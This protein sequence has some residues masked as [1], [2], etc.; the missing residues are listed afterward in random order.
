MNNTPRYP[1][2]L[3]LFGGSFDPIHSGHLILAEHVINEL[4]IPKILFMPAYIPPHKPL[5]GGASVQQ[6]AE[7][8]QA[9][10][11]D[12]DSFILGDY[13]IHRQ[14]VSYTIDTIEY[15]LHECGVQNLYLLIGEDSLQDFMTWKNY[16][17]IIEYC[18]LTVFRRYF[19]A[20]KNPMVREEDIIRI[21][22]PLIEISSTLIRNS[23]Q[24]GKSIRYLV[25]SAVEKYIH[26]NT[27]YLS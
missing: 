10:I 20:V 23:R 16:D 27:L 8:I 25:P 11:S 26:C 17:K 22:N 4:E 14:T 19:E 21:K 1:Q 5:S 2:T 13:E 6:R 7:M 18:T 24:S 12:N 9:A 15:L 3:C